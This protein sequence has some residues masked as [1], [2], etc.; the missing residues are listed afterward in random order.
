MTKWKILRN[1]FL[2]FSLAEHS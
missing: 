1:P 2:Q